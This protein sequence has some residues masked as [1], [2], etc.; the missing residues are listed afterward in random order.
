M[1]SLNADRDATSDVPAL[2]SRSEADRPVGRSAN[3]TLPAFG[4]THGRI[5]MGRV[6]W[7]ALVGALA[8][9]WG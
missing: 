1:S 5:D 7:G 3:A 6:F 9:S 8:V 2:A 4:D